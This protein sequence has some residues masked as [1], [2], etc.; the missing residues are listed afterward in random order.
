MRSKV[1]MEGKIL[2]SFEEKIE[3]TLEKLLSI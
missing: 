3:V 2:H 1:V